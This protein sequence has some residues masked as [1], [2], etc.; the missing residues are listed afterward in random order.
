MAFDVGCQLRQLAGSR[1]DVAL[2]VLGVHV[3][4]VEV[5]LHSWRDGDGVIAE[6]FVDEAVG[7]MVGEAIVIVPFHPCLVAEAPSCLFGE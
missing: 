3:Q 6:S 2:A 5:D 7:T 4:T 1:L